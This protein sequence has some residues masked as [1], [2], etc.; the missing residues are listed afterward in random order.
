MDL[1]GLR[2][3][4]LKSMIGKFEMLFIKKPKNIFGWIRMLTLVGTKNHKPKYFYYFQTD[5]IEI[6]S[7]ISLTWTLDRRIWRKEKRY[8]N[9]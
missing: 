1:N 3:K 6:H 5:K 9:Y 4:V 7:D 2:E 8:Y